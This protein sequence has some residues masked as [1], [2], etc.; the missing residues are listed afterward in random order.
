MVLANAYG[1]IGGPGR[2]NASLL[3][4]ITFKS[5]RG[6]TRI[7]DGLV[8][9]GQVVSYAQCVTS[10]NH[11]STAA[12]RL[13]AVHR[14]S[15]PGIPRGQ[16]ARHV[17]T[18]DGRQRRAQT[19]RRLGAI[20]RSDRSGPH[21]V[22]I[23]CKLDNLSALCC[24]ETPPFA[25]DAKPRRIARAQAVGGEDGYSTRCRSRACGGHRAAG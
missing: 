2:S 12:Y 4:T 13:S 6:Q 25:F 24:Y 3:S 17:S 5:G 10:P 1:P 8:L 9:L 7:L 21:V 19:K 14:A 22:A 11:S 16:P 15:G 18:G 23:C 20:I